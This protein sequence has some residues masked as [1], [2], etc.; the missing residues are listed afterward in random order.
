[1]PHNLYLHSS[2]VQT[3]VVAK[4]DGAKREAISLARIDTIVSL[5]LALVINASILILAGTAFHQP[6]QPTQAAIGIDDAYHLL[7]PI[8]GTAAAILFGLALLASGQSS[9]FTGTIAGQ[10]IMDGFLK[11]R[12]PCWQRRLITR[13]L[14]LGPALIGVMMLGENSVGRLLVLSQ[15]VLSLQLP[16]AMFPLLRLTGRADIMGNFRNAAY[17]SVLCWLLF[18]VISTANLWLVAQVFGLA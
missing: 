16:F 10:V 4:N 8:A 7:D 14:A 17:T 6:G 15:V 13:L 5:L 1:M 2:V 18:I 3:R 11:L 12:I 9:T